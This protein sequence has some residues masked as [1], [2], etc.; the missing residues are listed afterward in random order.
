MGAD[1]VRGV[2]G[3]GRVH[4]CPDMRPVSDRLVLVD[5][6]CPSASIACVGNERRQ[7]M[8]DE[9]GDDL[10]WNTLPGLLGETWC[11]LRLNDQA[12]AARRP[13]VSIGVPALDGV[14]G[15]LQ[16]GS[17]VVVSGA[18][19]ALRGS[20]L[21]HCAISS[22]EHNF[23]VMLGLGQPRGRLAMQA[24][25]ARA[26]VPLA[27]ME[28]G[29]LR[30]DGHWPALADAFEHFH[31]CPLVVL[32]PSVTSL[33]SLPAALIQL[34]CAYAG[35]F[36]LVI[37]DLDQLGPDGVQALPELATLAEQFGMA[38]L[39]GAQPE[40][41]ARVQLGGAVHAL[42]HLPTLDLD[43]RAQEGAFSVAVRVFPDSQGGLST[44]RLEHDP[45]SGAWREPLVV[46][47]PDSPDSPVSRREGKE[48]DAVYSAACCALL[49]EVG[50]AHYWDGQPH[51]PG[52]A[53]D[54]PHDDLVSDEQRLV[55]RVALDIWDNQG[56]VLLR[57]LRKLPAGMVA[58]VG[59]L[60][61]GT[62]SSQ[63][64][65]RWVERHLG[66]G[67]QHWMAE[68]RW[69]ELLGVGWRELMGRQLG[70]AEL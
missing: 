24:V 13:A 49:H 6:D 67:W 47:V 14:L 21:L 42:V 5:K 36:L 34:N 16:P 48:L 20:L 27:L 40:L 62:A 51:G 44:L 1:P 2:R 69:Q 68:A 28:R 64:P 46:S 70:G 54:L 58:D 10:P 9:Y 60:I 8:S 29:Q 53:W 45:S 22:T 11:E 55:V 30:R 50:L 41:A 7:G 37:D 3:L 19:P 65:L 61:A 12:D 59:E 38:L 63:G 25:A 15:P 18:E 31:D 56:G 23:V 32:G 57:D 52:R 43:A 26:G 33:V 39:V 35:P 17:V 66:E 4:S